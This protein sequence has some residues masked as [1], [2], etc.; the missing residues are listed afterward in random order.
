MIHILELPIQAQD[1]VKAYKT[2]THFQDIYHYI[3]DRKLLSGSKAQNCIHAE[4]LNYVIFNNF[5]FRIDTQKDKDRNKGNLFLLVIPEKYEPIIFHMHYDSLLAG[6][7][8]PFR[9][10]M[11]IRQ[12]FFIYNLM[13]KVKRYIEACHIGLKTKPQYMKNR[14][15]Y[16]QIPVVYTPM[17]DLLIDIKTMLQAFG[18]YHL[19]LVITCDQ[20][21]FT[22]TVPLRDRQTQTIAEALI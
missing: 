18:A 20:T 10:T 5:L 22:I 21:N 15:V 17:Q 19:L 13:N 9:T 4:A 8:G 16:R 11:T 7:Q 3:T 6:H 12:K 1:L 14:P 2:S